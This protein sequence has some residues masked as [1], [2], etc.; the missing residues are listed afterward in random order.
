MAVIMESSPANSSSVQWFLH[1]VEV[2][3]RLSPANDLCTS[4]WSI[5]HLLWLFSAF[6][7]IAPNT[8]SFAFLAVSFVNGSINFLISH[9]LVKYVNYIF[10][11]LLWFKILDII[12]LLFHILFVKEDLLSGVE[13]CHSLLC[14]DFLF[15]ACDLLG[16]I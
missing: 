3:N 8:F 15:P 12:I 13:F 11:L 16:I 9:C 5:L 4:Q 10:F 7:L 6:S 1:S 14:W 2:V